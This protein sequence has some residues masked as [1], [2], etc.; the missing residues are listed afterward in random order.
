[1]ENQYPQFLEGGYQRPH[2]RFLSDIG[3][4]FLDV[5][6]AMRQMLDALPANDTMPANP[7]I[8]ATPEDISDFKERRCMLLE[9]RT[10]PAQCEEMFKNIQNETLEDLEE[11]TSVLQGGFPQMV[12][13]ALP[14]FFSQPGCDDGLIP[15]ESDE[16][17]AVSMFTQKGDTSQLEIDFATD[18]LGDGDFGSGEDGWGF[19]NMV[20]SDTNGAIH[21]SPRKRN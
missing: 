6:A 19:L 17:A 2:K 9:G 14:P 12:Q 13:D 8:C 4:L 16:N 21:N 5:R 7:S 18:M 10:T 20:L 11:L 1:M 15:Y 3:N